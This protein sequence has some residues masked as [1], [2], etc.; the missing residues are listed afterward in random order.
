MSLRDALIAAMQ[1][2]AV[3]APRH[4]SIKGWPELYVRDITVDEVDAQAADTSDKKDKSRFARAACRII[5]DK[6][7]R[8]LFSPDDESDVAL[9][10]K[11]PWPMLRKVINAADDDAGN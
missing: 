11:Q 5:V 9:L 7:G 8:P 4:V 1:V 6:D 10:G 3:R 2:T